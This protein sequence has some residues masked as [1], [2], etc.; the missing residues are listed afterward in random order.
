MK[1]TK[2]H[3]KASN[4]ALQPEPYFLFELPQ[5]EVTLFKND[6]HAVFTKDNEIVKDC[7]GEHWCIYKPTR[8]IKQTAKKTITLD[9][10]IITLNWS[11]HYWHYHHETL[12][13]F[14]IYADLGVFKTYT[15]ENT[16]ILLTWGNKILD[17]QKESLKHIFNF[18]IFSYDLIFAERDVCYTTTKLLIT[19]TKTS[20]AGCL[21]LSYFSEKLEK[22]LVPEENPTNFIYVGRDDSD[23]RLLLN[24]EEILQFLNDHGIPIRK[25]TLTGMPY[26]EQVQLFRN[27]KFVMVISGSGSTNQIYCNPNKAKILFVS[28]KNGA[29]LCSQLTTQGMN[30]AYSVLEGYEN[31]TPTNR[32]SDP[33]CANFKL[34]KE[35]VLAKLQ[36]LL[37]D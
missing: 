31:F 22:Y 10:N 15:P 8:D 17:H 14:L 36:Q 29:L 5:G 12:G 16:V 1:K 20:T 9:K 11:G 18:N 6:T 21:P 28:P 3:D 25:V 37:K 26:M 23:C 2:Y 7:S 13:Q 35:D 24:Q 4:T 27:A 33:T 32:A 30:M 34:R 19:T